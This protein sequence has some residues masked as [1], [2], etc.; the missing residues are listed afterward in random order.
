MVFVPVS[1]TMGGQA[2]SLLFVRHGQSTNNLIAD[3]LA[4]QQVRS[5]VEEFSAN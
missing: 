3:E 5:H 2:I 4:E 1:Q